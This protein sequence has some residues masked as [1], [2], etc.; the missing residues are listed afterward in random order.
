MEKYEF[1]KA[2]NEVFAFIDACNECIQKEKPWETKDKKIVFTNGCFDILHV[3][4]IRYLKEARKLGD[5]LIV[6]VNSDSSVRKIKPLRPINSQSERAEVLASLEM[7][8]FV[9]FL[10]KIL[11]I[12]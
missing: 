2:L 1:D 3:G 8:D 12:I 7:V 5:V 4:H 10:M 11:H 6:A 9:T